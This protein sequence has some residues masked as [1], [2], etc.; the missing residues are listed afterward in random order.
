MKKRYLALAGRIQD[1]LSELHVI[2]MRARRAWKLAKES[3]DELYLDSVALNLHSFYTALE[4]IFELI[5]TTV[6]GTKPQGENWH[7]GL[8]RQ[9]GTDIELTRPA[10]ISRETRNILDEYRGFR[11]VVRNVYSFELSESKIE[12]LVEGLIPLFDKVKA[13]LENFIVFLD[14][15]GK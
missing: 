6:D 7:Y 2:A 1:E 11:H 12:P 13:E 8:L 3:G 4:R 10:I 9:M 15:N 14:A 5:A